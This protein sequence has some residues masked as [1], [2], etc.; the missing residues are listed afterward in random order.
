MGLKITAEGDSADGGGA[1]ILVEDDLGAFLFDCGGAVGVD[2]LPLLDG[3]L[4]SHAHPESIAGIPYLALGTRVFA[5]VITAA[6]LKA[7]QEAAP[8]GRA[9]EYVYSLGGGAADGSPGGEE[10]DGSLTGEASGGPLA[11]TWR[12]RPYT[13]LLTQNDSARAVGEPLDTFSEVHE[14]W[15]GQPG[16]L[17][18]SSIIERPARVLPQFAPN[19]LNGRDLR[20]YPVD[21]SILGAS[22]IAVE[23]PDGWVGYVGGVRFHGQQPGLM[24]EFVEG[25]SELGLLALIVDGAE[26]EAGVAPMTENDVYELVMD[27][28]RGRGGLVVADFDVLDIERFL[29]FNYV[30]E[31]TGRK[32]V[33]SLRDAH[34]IHAMGIVWRQFPAL[35][36]VGT[37]RV[38][39]LPPADGEAQQWREEARRRCAS[40]LVSPE[41]LRGNGGEYILRASA[42][43]S[44]AVGAV[45]AQGVVHIPAY[46]NGHA[47]FDEMTA[48]IRRIG[49]RHVVHAG[50]GGQA[51]VVA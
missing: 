5:S 51:V 1:R 31:R 49:A 21:H 28:V 44:D 24:E 40:I 41:E 20:H 3:V 32:V 39:D 38:L 22:A 27:A 25:F 18:V 45:G 30:A 26:T 11:R 4:V 6:I 16:I 9:H 36:E 35:D 47:T 2:S 34:M 43:E 19:A 12:Q 37:L 46:D 15:G 23:T 13:F 29:T 8:P 48:M 33:L 50:R 10:G 14:W 17:G 7:S 42:G